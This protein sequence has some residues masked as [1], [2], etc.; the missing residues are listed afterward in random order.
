MGTIARSKEATA[1]LDNYRYT[2][3]S[4]MHLLTEPALENDVEDSL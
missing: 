4:R 2:L 3:I 1:P